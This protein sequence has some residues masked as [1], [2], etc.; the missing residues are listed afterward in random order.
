MK[1]LQREE[2]FDFILLLQNHSFVVST[3]TTIIS[4][5]RW[6]TE[7]ELNEQENCIKF[8]KAGRCAG[9]L[10]HMGDTRKN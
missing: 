10:Y 7:W 5:T 9:N 3:K 2:R 6:V 1:Q 8:L 4:K